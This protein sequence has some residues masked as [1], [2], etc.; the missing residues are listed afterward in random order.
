M[1]QK[2]FLW[3]ELTLPNT[4]ILQHN[5]EYGRFYSDNFG[6]YPSVTTM[7]QMIPKERWVREWEERTPI[8]D[9]ERARNRAT[10]LGTEVHDIIEKYLNGKTISIGKL[11][12]VVGTLALKLIEECKKVDAVYASERFLINHEL[13]YAGTVDFCG[14]VGGENE[15]WD[16]KTGR[17]GG[18]G[19]NAP[20]NY[21]VQL[22]LY[23]LALEDSTSE[24]FSTGRIILTS[25][26]DGLKVYPID[27]EPYKERARLLSR[28]YWKKNG[29]IIERVREQL[30]RES[31]RDIAE[32]I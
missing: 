5:T 18:F 24:R 17:Y 6:L 30:I 9:Q 22:A 21:R 20:L 10:K 26:Y 31:Q 19:H 27:L 32:A 15:V 8:E 7:L 2:T 29:E 25:L 16:F 12:P 13:A 23:A 28:H 3:Q 1:Y 14:V 4:N 11:G